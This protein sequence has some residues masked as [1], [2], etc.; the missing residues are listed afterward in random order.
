VFTKSDIAISDLTLRVAGQPAG[1]CQGF[2]VLAL[3]GVVGQ[4]GSV[5]ATRVAFEGEPGPDTGF[6]AYNLYGGLL[7]QGNPE[8]K[9]DVQVIGSRFKNM[10]EAIRVW[11]V[12]ESRVSIGGSPADANTFDNHVIGIYIP[13]ADQSV[14]NISQNTVVNSDVGMMI[15]QNGEWDHQPAN[16]TIRHNQMTV[17][18]YSSVFNWNTGIVVVDLL[19]AN[20]GE[21]A[22]SFELSNNDIRLANCP[23]CDGIEVN[24][25]EGAVVTGN[26]LSGTAVD[27][28]WVWAS[29]GCMLKANNLLTLT[30]SWADILLDTDYLDTPSVPTT[31]CTV[32]GGDPKNTIWM[33]SESTDNT[34]VGVN[35][36]HRNPPGPS[37]RN[38][39][40]KKAQM[41]KGTKALQR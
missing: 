3:L 35:N 19:P 41:G 26:K 27:G 8:I 28:I 37:V 16:F 13:E 14:V 31:N 12:A 7:V 11:G 20:Y 38:A 22:S 5:S 23:A 40:L 6:G 33:D 18:G 32:V 17:S 24:V 10:S 25:T 2:C 15:V 30:S 29:D 9:A 21:P 4:T 39:M 1:G 36:M 34:L